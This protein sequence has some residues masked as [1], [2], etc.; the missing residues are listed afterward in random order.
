MREGTRD[1]TAQVR[2]EEFANCGFAC[3]LPMFRRQTLR[4][5]T[6]WNVVYE[7]MP[8]IRLQL[9]LALRGLAEEKKK[10]VLDLFSAKS[11]PA[12]NCF[13]YETTVGPFFFALRLTNLSGVIFPKVRL[14]NSAAVLPK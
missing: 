7:N 6:L 8:L 11:D 5:G 13:G 4:W 10:N 2:R 1:L 3:L 14:A 12:K 9:N